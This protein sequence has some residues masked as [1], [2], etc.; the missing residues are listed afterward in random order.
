MIRRVLTAVALVLV[1]GGR[2]HLVTAAPITTHTV[3]YTV[4]LGDTLELI[5]A[6]YYGDRTHAVFI[7]VANRILHPRPL[8]PGEILK[9]PASRDVITAPG[10]SWEALATAYLGDARRGQ[11]LAEFNGLSGDETLAAG[12]VLSVPFQVMRTSDTDE[13]LTSIAAAYFGDAKVASML[14]RYNF[15]A[16]PVLPRGQTLVVPIYHVK[17]RTSKLPAADADSKARTERRRVSTAAAA[18]ALPAAVAAWRAGDW[19]EVKRRLASLDVDY[20][21][22]A[23]AVDAGILLG[24]AY[25]AY[26]DADS[27]LAAFKHVLERRPRSTLRAYATSP[28][29]RDVWRR[30]G[31]LIDEG[32]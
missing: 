14:Q 6:E 8:K 30:A 24:S 7:M 23:Q 16:A 19:A 25:V 4:R 21:D 32:R 9:I 5:A 18:A 28:K 3:D 27:A 22:T 12:T 2:T 17:V 11:F 31:G 26:G 13:S 29:I 10:D 20:I 15:L 1:L